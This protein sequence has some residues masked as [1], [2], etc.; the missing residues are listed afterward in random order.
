MSF[1]KLKCGPTIFVVNAVKIYILKSEDSKLILKI[2]WTPGD[3]K[4][5][6]VVTH[7]KDG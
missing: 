2:A 4:K 1:F 5:K 7:D 3:F 6:S